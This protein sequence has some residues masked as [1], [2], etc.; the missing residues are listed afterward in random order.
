MFQF[1][2]FF[3]LVSSRLLVWKSKSNFKIWCNDID[4]NGLIL[5]RIVVLS[6]FK[7]WLFQLLKRSAIFFFTTL[8]V[9]PL[10]K[11]FLLH[12]LFYSFSWNK[13]F[14]FCENYFNFHCVIPHSSFSFLS[15]STQFLASIFFFNTVHIAFLRHDIHISIL[16]FLRAHLLKMKNV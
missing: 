7:D 11:D 1:Q 8:I 4:R 6:L 14:S 9:A 5:K 2:F 13:L 12:F 3:S 16:W 15:N 10:T